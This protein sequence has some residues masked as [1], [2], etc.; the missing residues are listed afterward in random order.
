MYEDKQE[1][2]NALTIALRTTKEFHD[3]TLLKYVK[4]GDHEVVIPHFRG[5]SRGKSINVSLDSCWALIR[6]VISHIK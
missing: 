2:C 6:D 3:L 1:T 5:G 4:D